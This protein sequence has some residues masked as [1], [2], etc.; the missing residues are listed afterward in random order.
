MTRF[1]LAAAVA[2]AAATPAVAQDAPAAAPA[3]TFNGPRIGLNVGFADPEDIFG[4]EAFTW[5]VEAGY[6]ASLGGVV[7]GATAEFQD[8]KDTG[9]DLS[10]VGRVGVKPTSNVL[11]YGLAG[12]SNLK[13]ID[14]LKL[15]GVR[16]GGGVEV[17]P[18]EGSPVSFK[19]EQRYT[20][21][22]LGAEVYQTLVG[23]G[24]HL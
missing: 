2:I 11:V 18:I 16:V 6:D 8:S 13:V 15:D 9:R 23:I 20:N 17:V 24:F 1:L 10:A 7:V 21:Y 4:T 22:E 3:D 12:Y 19:I 5:G 14:G